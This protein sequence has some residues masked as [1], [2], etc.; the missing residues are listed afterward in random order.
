MTPENWYRFWAVELRI[1][2]RESRRVNAI[3]NLIGMGITMKQRKMDI[4]P[5]N[6]AACGKPL[7]ADRRPDALHC[8]TACQQL[9]GQR[10]ANARRAL[11][12]RFYN[13]AEAEF[14]I[15]FEKIMLALERTT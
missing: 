10:R 14:P 13:L 15:Q 4:T 6:C 8:D 2:E 1:A 3:A 12:M 9:A 7:S 11:A 5:A